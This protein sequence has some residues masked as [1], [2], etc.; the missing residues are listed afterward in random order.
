MQ[1]LENA[2]QQNYKWAKTGPSTNKEQ[3]NSDSILSH[4]CTVT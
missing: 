4:T 3:F 1:R 2:D